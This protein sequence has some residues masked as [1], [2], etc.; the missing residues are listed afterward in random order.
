[1]K[2]QAA[3][4]EDATFFMEGRRFAILDGK[5]QAFSET[6]ATDANF[7]AWVRSELLLMKRVVALAEEWLRLAKET[8]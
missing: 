8:K 5:P 1:M 3:K 7:V 4:I 6:P 2:K